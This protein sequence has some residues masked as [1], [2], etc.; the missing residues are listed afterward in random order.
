VKAFL[1]KRL[2]RFTA[3]IEEDA[4]SVY[5]CWM[6]FDVLERIKAKNQKS[7]KLWSSRRKNL[8]IVTSKLWHMLLIL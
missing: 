2:V 1:K 4:S 5:P 8:E 6:P 7:S 3:T